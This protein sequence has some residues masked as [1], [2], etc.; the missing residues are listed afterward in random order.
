MNS[1]LDEYNRGIFKYNIDKLIISKE[2]LCETIPSGEEYESSIE[3][4]TSSQVYIKGIAYSS[5]EFVQII[6]KAFS[7]IKNSIRF[8]VITGFDNYEDIKGNITIVTNCGEV[9][10]PFV[11]NVQHP[12]FDS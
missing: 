6:D 10:V 8:K 3:L 11:F 1:K 7:G 12:K 4:T 2:E 5:H 9:I